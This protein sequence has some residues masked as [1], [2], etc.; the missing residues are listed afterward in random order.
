M[1]RKF[2]SLILI[3]LSAIL[4]FSGCG[5]GSYIESGSDSKKPSSSDG[6]KPGGSEEPGDNPGTE[7]TEGH[8]TAELYLDNKLFLP[9]DDVI[10]VIWKSDYEVHKAELDANGKADAGELDGTYAVYLEGLPSKY[11]YNP[12]KYVATAE[13]KKVDILITTITSPERGYGDGRGDLYNHMMLRY[14]GTYRATLNSEY[15]VLQYAYKPTAAG[16]YS[17]VSWVNAYEDNTNPYIDIYS[18]N[19]QFK[20]FNRTL[21]GGEP[22]PEGA[23]KTGGYT[24]NFRYEVRIDA[25]EV[26]N[27]FCFAIHASNKAGV[28]P[29]TVDFAITYEGEYTSSDSNIVVIR[30]NEAK[31][32]AGNENGTFV[33]ADLGTK[34]FDNN[35]FK[36]NDDTGRYHYYSME[37]YGNDPLGYGAGYGPVLY[38]AIDMRIP[39][40]TLSTLFNADKT[41]VGVSF[42]YL[43]LYNVWVESEQTFA[44]YDYTAFIKEDYKQVCNDDGVCYVTKELKQFLQKFAENHSLY[45]DHV[46]PGMGTPEALGYTANQDAL[47][48]FACGIYM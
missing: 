46:G 3:V 23:P 48:L 19:E 26:G 10:N 30:A 35:N 13:S 12:A 42:N 20:I 45:T 25:K 9:G 27:A 34:V 32:K 5:L 15:D 4:C 44:V 33:F 6:N 47:W 41:G 31:Y 11:T 36:Y 39:S 38:C 22:S 28:Y 16:Y 7:D 37:K 17:I 29:V 18:G 43:K 1:K 40:Y 21:D 2:L 14:N 24:K 8:Y